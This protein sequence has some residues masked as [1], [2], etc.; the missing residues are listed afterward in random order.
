MMADL[1]G[2]GW[3][4]IYVAVDFTQNFLWINQG[5]RTFVDVAEACGAD[6]LMNDMGM[7]IVDYDDDGDFDLYTTNVYA[8]ELP[9]RHN[10]MLR[11]DSNGGSL[12]FSDVSR[13]VGL[14]KGAWGWGVTAM[15]ADRDGLVDFA[16]T[17]GFRSPIPGAGGSVPDDRSRLWLQD[18]SRPGTFDEVGREVKFADLFWGSN[19]ISFD[20]D[21]DG[22]LD[23]LQ[24]T[25]DEKLRLLDNR[26]LPGSA[27]EGHHYLVVAPRMFGPNKR[28]IGAVVRVTANG[29]RM[30]RLVSAGTSCLGQEPAEAFFGLGQAGTADRLEIEYPDGRR[31]VLFDVPGDQRL[32]LWP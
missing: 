15:D 26:P 4:D 22:D 30:T 12:A 23:L 19:L 25:M 8:T 29:R 16:A 5:D 18:P 6:I 13:D 32:E 3:Q 1:D 31:L 20:Y 27:A 7:S 17:N 21:R 28:A 9:L 10:A 14:A 2:D 11:N 24:S